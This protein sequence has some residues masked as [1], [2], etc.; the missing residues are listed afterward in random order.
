MSA[1]KGAAAHA[2]ASANAM[3]SECKQKQKQKQKLFYR[4][5]P[6]VVRCK[7]EPNQTSVPCPRGLIGAA[8]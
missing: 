8:P 3:Q 6:V 5:K 2:S 1:N 4:S 7:F